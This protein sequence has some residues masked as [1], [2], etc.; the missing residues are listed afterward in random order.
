MREIHDR[1]TNL[2][3]QK[4]SE[5]CAWRDD[6]TT[7]YRSVFNELIKLRTHIADSISHLVKSQHIFFK[8]PIFI[9]SHPHGKMKYISMGVYCGKERESLMYTTATCKGSSGGLVL[10]LW[11]KLECRLDSHYPMPNSSNREEEEEVSDL[12]LCCNSSSLLMGKRS[13][14]MPHSNTVSRTQINRC[15]EGFTYTYR[16]Q[17]ILESEGDLIDDES[18]SDL[19][20]ERERS[21]TF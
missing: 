7:S 19:E 12:F 8:L 5:L 21:Y 3:D 18:D 13:V 15:A 6:M 9:I 1:L 20:E 11:P 14:T 17:D 10:P 16:L 2:H 4:L